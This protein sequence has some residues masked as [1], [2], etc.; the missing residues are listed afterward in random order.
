[1]MD[2][3][4]QWKQ[5]RRH[6]LEAAPALRDPLAPIGA[7]GLGG[8]PERR[9]PDIPRAWTAEGGAV[10]AAAAG[11]GEPALAERPFGGRVRHAADDARPAPALRAD[12]GECQ[13]GRR[14]EAIWGVV[15]TTL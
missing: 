9:I 3:S 4:D 15:A 8:H 5:G 11:A 14:R 13:A 10:A 2:L 12:L 7:S 6:R 1:M